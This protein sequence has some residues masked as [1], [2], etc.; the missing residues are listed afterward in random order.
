MKATNIVWIGN[1]NLPTEVDVP[2]NYNVFEMGEWLIEKY[3]CDIESYHV[4]D[5]EGYNIIMVEP[6]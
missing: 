2:D 3:H 5:G 6:Y 1:K 4:F